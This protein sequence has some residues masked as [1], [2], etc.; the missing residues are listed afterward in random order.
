MGLHLHALIS[1][2]CMYISTTFII[3]MRMMMTIISITVVSRC[4]AFHGITITVSVSFCIFVCCVWP[5][6][7]LYGLPK[8]CMKLVI[9]GMWFVVGQNFRAYCLCMV[10]RKLCSVYFNFWVR[11]HGRVKDSL[12]ALIR[13]LARSGWRNTIFRF[14]KLIATFSH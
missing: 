10:Y 7:H 12:C 3:I 8:R 13:I 4:P 9:L 11:W 1:L 2:A 14:T 6:D 5:F